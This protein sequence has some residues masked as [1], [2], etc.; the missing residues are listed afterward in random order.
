MP[1]GRCTHASLLSCSCYLSLVS[2]LSRGSATGSFEDPLRAAP[3]FSLPPQNTDLPIPLGRPK[4][5]WFQ[6]KQEKREAREKNPASG[7]RIDESANVDPDTGERLVT[8]KKVLG[9][10]GAGRFG[11]ACPA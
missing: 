2:L 1:T 5:T 11:R 8:K 3:A 6:T 4:K 7:R 9:I 10:R